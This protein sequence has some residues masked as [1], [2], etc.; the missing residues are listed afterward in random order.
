MADD[1][2]TEFDVIVIG[3]GLSEAITAAALTR[4]GKK[5]LHV[6]KNDYYGGQWAAFTFDKLLAWIE[7]ARNLKSGKKLPPYIQDTDTNQKRLL[8]S[9]DV[10]TTLNL[11]VECYC[12]KAPEIMKDDRSTDGDEIHNI[13][14]IEMA[15]SQRD[16]DNDESSESPQSQDPSSEDVEKTPNQHDA[17]KSENSKS[18]QLQAPSSGVADQVGSNQAIR[19]RTAKEFTYQDLKDLWR[20]FSIDLLPK[21]LLC[22]G[23]LVELL[24]K[25]KVARYVEFKCVTKI[26]TY[27][28]NRLVQVPCSRSEV[29]STNL[30][31]MLEKRML[32][33]FLSF[34]IEYEKHE[35]K[36]KEYEQRPFSD[37]LKSWR[38]SEDLQHFI[39][40]CIAMVEKN[41]TTIE[42]LAAAQCFLQSL[43]R[44]GETPFLWPL[45]GVAELPQAF[46]RLCAVF[47]G[48]YCLRM[49]VPSL[50]ID[51]TS[52]RCTGII[53]D[54]GQKI[55]CSNV[56]IDS[57]YLPSALLSDEPDK[58]K[59]ISR[60]IFITNKSIYP[61]ETDE[62]ILFSLPSSD[63]SYLIRG[64]EISAGSM[65]C[66]EG[67]YIVHLTCLMKSNAKD[68]LQ[69][70]TD[71]LFN[72]EENSGKDGN[73]KPK[74]LWC[75]YFNQI[76]YNV[77]ERLPSN[78]LTVDPID[79][80]MSFKSIVAKA[81]NMYHNI[82]PNE[83]FIPS[84]PDPEDIIIDDTSPQKNGKETGENAGFSGCEENEE[85][86]MEDNEDENTST[87]SSL[88]PNE[89]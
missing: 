61:T 63:L 45:Y 1:L 44:F 37:Y 51:E 14:E 82:C 25:S 60:A 56:I 35:D 19:D 85:I 30:M 42:G 11:E 53:T 41:V 58:E 72:F 49:T 80:E 66:P 13:E 23:P 24:I 33:K 75:T 57:S 77:K 47:G 83:E 65:A 73:K 84:P 9:N 50:I 64:L 76:G 55:S 39:I 81:E 12:D 48:I 28:G 32:M 8:L 3:T 10:L 16:A 5:V 26:L 87:T 78:I 88:K 29:F 54:E 6:D 4:I 7:K 27:R 20:R 74:V 18:P 68:D 70:V 40:H 69:E 34:C 79:S 2:P 43:G 67:L 86:Q 31:S 22:R 46:C 52:N 89:M 62:V 71:S 17:D 15:Q 21:L 38:L 59:S 36:F